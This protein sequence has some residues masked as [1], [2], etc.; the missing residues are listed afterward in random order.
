[1]YD[2][3]TYYLTTVSFMLQIIDSMICVFIVSLRNYFI[4]FSLDFFNTYYF[5]LHYLFSFY[6]GISFKKN[7]IL[8]V[9]I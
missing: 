3:S 7:V 6:M 2:V 4:S 1:M 5:S 8:L 9:I